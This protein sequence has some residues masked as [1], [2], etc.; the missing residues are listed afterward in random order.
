MPCSGGLGGC[1]GRESLCFVVGTQ[2]HTWSQ[3]TSGDVLPVMGVV[4]GDK[5]L[6]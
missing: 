2:L 5:V 3:S 6:G 1:H 4:P